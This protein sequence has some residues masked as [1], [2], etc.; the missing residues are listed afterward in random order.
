MRE[1]ARETKG[2]KLGGRV[3]GSS[4]P[5]TSAKEETPNLFLPEA[6]Q[7]ADLG[8]REALRVVQILVGEGKRVCACACVC[9]YERAAG[10]GRREWPRSGGVRHAAC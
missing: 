6:G 3:A 10:A 9:V 8:L 7:G 2:R 1:R 5:S 4:D